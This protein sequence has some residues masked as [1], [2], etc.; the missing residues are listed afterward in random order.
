MQ[1][2]STRCSNV[3]ANCKV[4]VFKRQ[5]NVMDTRLKCWYSRKGLFTRNIHVKYQSYRT[6]CSKVI[7]KVKVYNSI[8]KF[9]NYGMADMPPPPFRFRWRK[10]GNILKTKNFEQL[11]FWATL[12]W[13][14][15]TERKNKQS[16]ASR[17]VLLRWVNN[18]IRKWVCVFH[19]MHTTNPKEAL[20]FSWNCD[21]KI[22]MFLLVVK[23][24]I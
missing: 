17:W 14:Y 1:S 4:K 12:F 19:M 15:F 16:L 23:L 6:Y 2:P 9:Q 21:T 5:V 7:S 22:A 8:S 13:I 10:N 11:F 3:I 24:G 18:S 20:S